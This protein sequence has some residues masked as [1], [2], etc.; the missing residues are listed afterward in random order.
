M[1][2]LLTRIVYSV[3]IGLLLFYTGCPEGCNITK[4]NAA[5]SWTITRVI[6]GESRNYELEFDGSRDKGEIYWTDYFVGFYDYTDNV[7]SFS[8]Q[9]PGDA[10]LEFDTFLETYT[11][12]ME[13]NDH[14]SGTVKEYRT[15][16]LVQGTWTAVRI[17]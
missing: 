12:E 15:D 4:W 2:N 10:G 3:V 17:Q 9:M 5:G 14:M 8:M 7:M 1:K 16:A 6:E 11:G 13:D